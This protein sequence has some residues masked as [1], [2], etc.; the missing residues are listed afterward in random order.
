MMGIDLQGSGAR[1][2]GPRPRSRGCGR[3]TSVAVVSGLLLLPCVLFA[4][5]ARPGVVGWRTDTSGRYPDATP[6]L[7]WG[8]E[9]NVAWV[10]PLPGGSPAHPVIVSNRI[11]VLDEPYSLTCIDKTDGS[12]K[13]TRTNAIQA[14]IGPDG[15][16]E[17]KRRC[18]AW[19]AEYEEML[20]L[21]LER[22]AIREK[23]MD[24]PVD[25]PELTAR[26]KEIA[27]EIKGA[28]SRRGEL[29][30][31]ARGSKKGGWRI[32]YTT[33]TPVSNGNVVF[34][35]F[36][37]GVGALYDLAG[38]LKWARFLR[39]RVQGYGQSASPAMVGSV[40]G[41]HIDN[42]FFA[43]DLE[44]GRTL[45]VVY[46]LEHQGSPAG[47]HVGDLDVFVINDGN[48][49]AATNGAVVAKL[50][51]MRFHTPVIE[52]DGTVW[53]INN[54]SHLSG[55]RLLPD[56]K[57]GVKKQGVGGCGAPGKIYW[58][59]PLIHNGLAYL[60]DG[61]EN[62]IHVFDLKTGK[63]VFEQKLGLGSAYV[64]PT[65]AGPFAF[66]A[67]AGGTCVVLEP[68][69][70]T[71]E[72]GPGIS[73]KIR[74]FR[75][76]ARNRLEGFWACPVFE[77]DKLYMRTFKNLYC[78]QATDADRERSLPSKPAKP[79]AKELIGDLEDLMDL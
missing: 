26:L 70:K 74:D 16:D 11:F 42:D 76:V 27:A 75:T 22:I 4:G 60:W 7:H 31:F 25:D 61:N 71:V 38:D 33:P 67:G 44:T 12:V 30:Q 50:G 28:E 37:N 5:G 54:D 57:G 40:I 47:M 45:W 36:G 73:K 10:A 41:V 34:A 66:V 64:S 79:E 56:G 13:W 53:Y 21:E 6:P 48:V 46:E 51:L 9:K 17:Y 62:E 15:M 23:L 77:G 3:S 55:V 19:F 69:W 18:N 63:Q 20:E 24:M 78:F 72:L 52:E 68:G 1:S 8:P 29:P 32:G 43:L 59:S 35:L 49:R 2:P 14:V 39:H 65:G 58:S